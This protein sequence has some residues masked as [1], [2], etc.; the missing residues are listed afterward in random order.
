MKWIIKN[1][2]KSVFKAIPSKDNLKSA[3]NLTETFYSGGHRSSDEKPVH[4]NQVL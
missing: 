1:H 4:F 2:I 3:I